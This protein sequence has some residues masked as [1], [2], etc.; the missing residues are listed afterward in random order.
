LDPFDFLQV[1][2]G[3]IG[4]GLINGLVCLKLKIKI[5]SVSILFSWF[6]EDGDNSDELDEHT[7]GILQ[8]ANELD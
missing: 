2:S 5:N 1:S 3:G 7:V 6:V 4:Y 8:E